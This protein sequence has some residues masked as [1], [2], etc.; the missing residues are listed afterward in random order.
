MYPLNYVDL[1]LIGVVLASMAAGWRRGFILGLSDLVRWTGA[2]LLALWLYQYVMLALESLFGW[3]DP[4]RAPAAFLLSVLAGVGIMRGLSRLLLGR[5]SG[6]AHEHPANRAFGLLAGGLQGI[7]YAAILATLM[8]SLP[9]PGNPG[10]AARQSGMAN[11]LA[12]QTDRLEGALAPEIQECI[13]ETLTRLLVRPESGESVRLPFTVVSPEARPDLEARMLVLLNQER[14]AEG[15]A[16]LSADTALRSVARLH[17]TDMFARGY[18]SHVS[19][20]SLD[21]FDRIR[22]GGVRFRV[23]GENLALAPTLKIAHTGLMNSPG[24]RANILRPQFGRVGIGIM[25]GGRRG[26]MVTQNFRN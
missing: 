20:D 5:L 17:S 22:E 24:H 21:P 26:L 19:P 11:L 1:L 6:R 9:L 4:V 15:L 25:D 16:P 18:F 14:A 8:L 3:T 23:A 2:L 10:N 13:D 7:V 12:A